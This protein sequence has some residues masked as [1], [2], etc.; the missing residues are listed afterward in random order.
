MTRPRNTDTR[1]FKLKALRLL[2]TSGRSAE[3]V[4][5]ELGIGKGNLL[6]WQ[7]ELAADGRRASPVSGRLA[8]EERIRKLERENEILRQERDDLLRHPHLLHVPKAIRFQFIQDHGDEFPVT[9]MCKVL[10]VSHSGYYAWQTRPVSA[11]ER[12]NQKLFEKIK[13]VYNDHQG[14]YG[15][16]RIHRALKAQGVACSEN[17]IA[18]LMKLHGLRARQGRQ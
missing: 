4:E 17:R 13:T 5:R 10:K 16:P 6:R 3:Q 11:R 1:D 9:H 8:A 15:S 7:R 14:T 12:A 2:E 18:R